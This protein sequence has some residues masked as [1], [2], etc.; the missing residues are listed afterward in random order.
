LQRVGRVAVPGNLSVVSGEPWGYRNR[1]QFHIQDGKLGYR[2]RGSH[3]LVP[4]DQCPISSPRINTCIAALNRMMRDPRWPKFIAAIEVF[5]NEEQVQLNVLESGQSVAKRF[6]EWAAEEIPGLVPGALEY[7]GFR[8]SPN[9][10]FQVNR[11][12]VERMVQ[13]TMVGAEGREALDLYSGA[14]LFSVPLAERFASVTAVE[15]GSGAVRDLEF[16]A[17]RAGIRVHAVGAQVDEYLRTAEILPD[18]VLA[19][20]PRTG[21]GKTVVAKL[22]EWKPERLTLVSCDP[23]T[24]ARDLATLLAGGYAIQEFTLIDLF[25]Q[26][27][28]IETICRLHLR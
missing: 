18:F 1:A 26:T 13:L 22:V 14:G 17:A 24:L 3:Q 16:N 6:F 2:A 10:F 21:L 19:D 12:L 5:T 9:S 11:F 8:V 4:I 27:F 25:P 23:S 20:P 15:S 7:S 28:H